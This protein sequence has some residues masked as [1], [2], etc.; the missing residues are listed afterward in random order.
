VSVWEPDEEELKCL[1]EGGK[2]LLWIHTEP[3]PPV[4]LSVENTPFT[5]SVGKH[6]FK[7]IPELEDAERGNVSR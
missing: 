4:G 5:E 2:I 3:I 1:N 6:P 7:V